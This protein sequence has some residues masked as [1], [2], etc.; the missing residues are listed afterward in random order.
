M[1]NERATAGP[2]VTVLCSWL[3]TGIAV[4][5]APSNVLFVMN[6]D[7]AYQAISACGQPEYAAQQSRLFEELQRLRGELQVPS[8]DGASHLS[9]V[10]QEGE[11]PE[12]LPIPSKSAW[13][14]T[15]SSAFDELQAPAAAIDGDVN[16]RWNT[17]PEDGHWLQ[18]DLG[19]AATVAGA[20]V[21]WEAARAAKYRLQVSDEK[22]VW[23]T[24]RQVIKT[25]GLVDQLYFPPQSGRFWRIVCDERATPWGT[26]V[27]E[28]NFQGVDQQPTV[29]PRTAANKTSPSELFDGD[30]QTVWRAAEGGA[31]TILI[32]LQH[33]VDLAG[34]A[35]EWATPAAGTRARRLRLDASADGHDWK[36]VADATASQ[37]GQ[38]DV[39]L[40]SDQTTRFLRLQLS[41]PVDKLARLAICEVE[42]SGPE[43]AVIKRRPCPCLSDAPTGA[44]NESLAL[45]ATGHDSRVDLVW[46]PSPEERVC[47]YNIY[48]ASDVEGPFTKINDRLYQLSVYSDFVG[49][50]SGMYAYR[51]TTVDDRGVESAPSGTVTAVP[52][53]MTDDELLTSIQ[54]AAFRYFWDFASP[55]SGL[56]REGLTHP[57][58]TV[59]TGGTGFGMMTIMVAAERGFV[60]RAQAAERL[61]R[62]VRF[63]QHKAQRYHGVWSHWLNG[64][65][66]ETIAFAGRADNGGD[67]VETAFLIEGMLTVRQYFDG[68]SAVEKELRQRI[69]QVWEEVEWDWYLGEGENNRLYWH[70]SPDFGWKMSHPVTGFN[71]C[72]IAYLLAIASPTHPIPAESYY[73][74]WV[75]NPQEYADGNSYYGIVKPVGRREGQPL[76]FTHYSYLGLDPRKFSDRFCNYFENHRNTTLINRAYCI[77]NPGQ[78]QGYGK[79]VWG[80]TAS[81]NPSGYKAH[82]PARDRDDGTIA[83]TAAICALPYTPEESLATI[84]HLYHAHGKRLW[85]PFG[86]YDAF[87]LDQDWVSDTYLAIDQ[88]PMAPMIENHRSRLC[89]DRFMS[90]PEIE[91]MLEK[92]QRVTSAASTPTVHP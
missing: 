92:L 56:S 16:T 4:A 60:T 42:L 11:S 15:A 18:V 89:W 81:T 90:N 80:L 40:G 6:D 31:Q 61:L 43:E 33:D 84:R 17:A 79:L 70:W 5:S 55:V 21:H 67:I 64:S 49:Q 32:D 45:T 28:V 47:G 20:R 2:T 75:G 59:T 66:G 39:L 41:D 1:Q 72:M 29:L 13:V 54:E 73:D 87:N 51:V 77:E 48:R 53:A 44:A 65:T 22:D 14:A 9:M 68:D 24:V 91:T 37:A 63:L 58:E 71:E 57:C 23:R 8:D 86:F 26:S 46:R 38:R 52:H 74:G 69:T 7:H 27:R 50:N 35:I 83:P 3:L 62:M 85:G 88:G 78:H 36:F 10:P 12:S 30:R 82:A 19:Q 25:R 34:L 76:F